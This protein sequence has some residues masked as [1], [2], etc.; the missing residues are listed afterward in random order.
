M[1]RKRSD[2]TSA[3][4]TSELIGE[5]N[6]FQTDSQFD[7]TAASE[8]G[9]TSWPET[10][11]DAVKEAMKAGIKSPTEIA[12]WVKRTFGMDMTPAHVSTVKGILKREK[13]AKKQKKARPQ[14]RS[15]ESAEPTA[16]ASLHAAP[17]SSGPGL[18]TQDLRALVE[19]ADR[20]GGVNHLAE[21][22][23]VL[24]TRNPGE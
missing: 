18:T 5:G 15:S 11:Q 20:V 16:A 23:D 21:F 12:G 9:D 10:K 22:L 24:R 2:T 4:S 19:M 1:A 14:T 13:E 8:A 17:A 7:E 3:A 6:D